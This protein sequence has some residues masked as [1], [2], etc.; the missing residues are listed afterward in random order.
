MRCPNR[1]SL[2]GLLAVGATLMLGGCRAWRWDE[3]PGTDGAF[4]STAQERAK[5]RAYDGAPPVIPHIDLGTHC[6]GCHRDPGVAMR[7]V[8]FAPPSPHDGTAVAGATIRCRQCHVRG[9]GRDVFVKSDFVGLP[10]NLRS[11]GRLNAISPP[12]IPHRI[13]MRE[14]CMACHA[15]PAARQEIVTTHPERTRCRQCH[16]LESIRSEFV[17]NLGEGLASP[18]ESPTGSG[19]N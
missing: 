15:G 14:N 13:P 16:A 12:T 1:T 8:G 19:H 5:L 7:G 9:I 18:D 2:I 11:G 10:Q 3:V 6:S 4:K 17:S